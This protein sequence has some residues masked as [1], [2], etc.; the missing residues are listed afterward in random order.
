[1]VNDRSKHKAPD[2]NSQVLTFLIISAKKTL[3]FINSISVTGN[4]FISSDNISNRF[5]LS[6]LTLYYG[7]HTY[8]P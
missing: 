5:F 4:P 8:S 3:I 6:S 2:G 1:M 7:S